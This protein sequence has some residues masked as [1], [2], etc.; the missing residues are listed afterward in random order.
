MGAGLATSWGTAAGVTEGVTIKNL[1][2]MYDST[3]SALEKSKENF[4]HIE[5]N[6]KEGITKIEVRVDLLKDIMKNLETSQ[7]TAENLVDFSAMPVEELKSALEDLEK[8]CNDYNDDIS[9]VKKQK[10]S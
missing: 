3:R 8:S 2:K 6:I 1:K 7:G 5:A 4:N 9:T 10:K